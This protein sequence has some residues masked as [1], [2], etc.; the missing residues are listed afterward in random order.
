MGGRP[1]RMRY[2]TNGGDRKLKFIRPVFLAI[3]AL[4]TVTQ[5]SSAAEFRLADRSP[6]PNGYG[7]RLR[8][9]MSGPIESGDAKKLER[10]VKQLEA[11]GENL[12]RTTRLS[13]NSPGGSLDPSIELANT[14]RETGLDTYVDQGAQCLSGCAI[15]FM[16]GSWREGDGAYDPYKSMHP[17]GILG[18]HA[19]FAFAD[20]KLP[21]QVQ[22]LLLP[23]AERGGAIAASKLVKLSLKQMIPASLVEEL[24]QYKANTFLYIDTVDRAG[25]WKIA[26]EGEK[27]IKVEKAAIMTKH[28]RL[29]VHC[30]NHIF[31]DQDVSFD[32]REGSWG[33]SE[34]SLWFDGMDNGCKYESSGDQ[35]SYQVN[36]NNGTVLAWHTLPANTK[37]ADLTAEQL[38]AKGEKKD[39][40]ANPPPSQ[41][42][43]PC[44][45]GHQWIGGWAGAYWQDGIAHATYRRCDGSMEV[46]KYECRH[47]TGMISRSINLNAFGVSN[48]GKPNVTSQVDK[49]YELGGDGIILEHGMLKAKNT[50]Q[51]GYFTFEQVK[52]GKEMV[53][54]VDGN[55]HRIH[56]KGSRT[57]FEAMEKSC[58]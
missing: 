5:I 17:K 13:L 12:F 32:N 24:L 23:D 34:N 28:A 46:V 3:A 39:P 25:R 48:D 29:S 47:G 37:L 26:L 33:L 16:A 14:V 51:K 11:K 15:V 9:D 40:F 41:I 52:S 7:D 58:L 1:W 50:L 19:P 8:I 18:F 31:W 35:V 55:P 22:Q 49:E 10:L 20:K 54:R 2:C 57:A 38:G 27:P 42:D 45:R 56:L 4:M 21:K 6:D 30:E 36:G 44:H 43:G 53:I